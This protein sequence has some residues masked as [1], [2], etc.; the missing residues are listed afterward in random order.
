MFDDDYNEIMCLIMI[1]FPML[2]TLNRG[3]AAAEIIDAFGL[4][5]AEKG[6]GGPGFDLWWASFSSS[7]NSLFNANMFPEETILTVLRLLIFITNPDGVI[8]KKEFRKWIPSPA[9]LTKLDS[10]WCMAQFGLASCL[11]L[12]ARAY[13]QLHQLEDAKQCATLGL[14]NSE[15]LFVR[16]DCHRVVALIAAKEN[17]LATA[18]DHLTKA[19]GEA[20]KSGLP[21][22]RLLVARDWERL[23][24]HSE[25]GEESSSLI[26]TACYEMKRK[27]SDMVSILKSEEEMASAKEESRRPKINRFHSSPILC[28]KGGK[29]SNARSLSPQR[30]TV[31]FHAD[32]VYKE[33]KSKRQ[34]ELAEPVGLEAYSGSD[35]EI[36]VMAYMETLNAEGG[37]G[38]EEQ[39]ITRS[40]GRSRSCY[41]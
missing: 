39:P 36:D 38:E 21:M 20:S 6:T 22:L 25:F 2:Y 8:R 12:G 5:Y 32:T 3:K 16:M 33:M 41:K 13:L 37:D 14:L 24:P 31:N 40:R 18:E 11:G 4:E 26:E 30:H 19:L 9:L 35:G 28:R 15:K 17:D 34:Q 27:R 29:R 7:S 1:A 10:C 23:L